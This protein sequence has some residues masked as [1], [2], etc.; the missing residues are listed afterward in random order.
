MLMKRLLVLAV[1]LCSLA[2]VTSKPAGAVVACSCAAISCS[3]CEAVCD[4]LSERDIDRA[5][6]CC[7][8]AWDATFPDCGLASRSSRRVTT[9]GHGKSPQ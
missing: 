1:L 8:Q 3:E 6:R 4:T 7:E 2:F 5:V 9:V